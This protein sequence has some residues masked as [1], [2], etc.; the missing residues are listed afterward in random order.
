MNFRDFRPMCAKGCNWDNK[1]IKKTL[2]GL[3]FTQPKLDGIR[4]NIFIENDEVILQSR[5]GKV[6]K[7]HAMDDLKTEVQEMY[8]NNIINDKVL[9]D[10]ELYVH[11]LGFNDVQSLVTNIKGAYDANKQ[12]KFN[13]YD[14]YDDENPEMPF[15]DRRHK[16]KTYLGKTRSKEDSM[17]S[18]V[19]Y[20]ILD[21]SNLNDSDIRDVLYKMHDKYVAEGYEGLIIRTADGVYG[22][23][24]RPNDLLKLK[25]FK[26]EEY[27]I[28]AI[29]EGIGK[30]V[31]IP[32]LTLALKESD[33]VN[34]KNTTFNAVLNGKE[35]Y[36]KM[37]WENRD[38][39]IGQPCTVKF[40]EKSDD[41]VPRFPVV[42]GIRDYE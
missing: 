41:N 40:F 10:G 42:V 5:Q 26:D 11:G 12:C 18:V 14:M 36:R 37:I 22:V 38:S 39:Y 2:K 1:N 33:I 3:L 4:C 31:G 17:I 32:T 35:E 24:K 23:D 16:I 28:V 30:N 21:N 13:V 9:L 27:T 34:P 20:D 25:A 8:N 15:K 6:F 19:K 29:N 7:G